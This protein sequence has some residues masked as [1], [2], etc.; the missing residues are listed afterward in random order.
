MTFMKLHAERATQLLE[1]RFCFFVIGDGYVSHD[2]FPWMTT[3]MNSSSPGLREDVLI[4][5]VRAIKNQR[6][7]PSLDRV[8]RWLRFHKQVRRLE[9]SVVA[10]ALETAVAKGTLRKDVKEGREAYREWKKT[11]RER[12][13]GVKL[14]IASAICQ[15]IQQFGGS[16]GL[17]LD[18]ICD[19]VMKMVVFQDMDPLVLK[20]HVRMHCLKAV[21]RGKLLR[22]GRCYKLVR[23]GQIRW[24]LE[25]KKSEADLS[26]LVDRAV[27]NKVGCCLFPFFLLHMQ[28]VICMYNITFSTVI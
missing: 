22:E 12:R 16:E 18:R 28:I 7:R 6:Q 2:V 13:P 14:S 23:S 9:V 19:H 20:Y 21:K 1:V 15:C 10:A 27:T 8:C 5:A 3:K 11:P 25:D 17:A 24:N 4:E 26:F